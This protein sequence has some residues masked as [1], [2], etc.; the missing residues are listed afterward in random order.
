[1]RTVLIY[2]SLTPGIRPRYGLQP[3]GILYLAAK[4]ESALFGFG[5]EF[6][7]RVMDVFDKSL[8]PGLARPGGFG[9]ELLVFGRGPQAAFE[10]RA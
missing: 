7:E 9:A 1:M 10:H 2:P 3:L 4:L 8:L 6:P 5:Q